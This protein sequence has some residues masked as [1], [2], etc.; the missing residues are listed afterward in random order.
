[1]LFRSGTEALSSLEAGGIEAAI[2]DINMPELSGY[3]VAKL[4]RQMEPPGE[5]LPIIGL[6]AEA[7]SETDRLCREAGMDAAIVKPVPPDEMLALLTRLVEST[8][9]QRRVPIS[10]MVVTP[11]TAHPRFAR[12][13]AII[14][15]DALNALAG[16]GDDAFYHD[17]LE[18]FFADAE[19]ILEAMTEA[20]DGRDFKAFKDQIHAMRSSAVNVGAVR[21]CQ[22]LQDANEISADELGGSAS[23][24]ALAR[25]RGELGAL[26]AELGKFTPQRRPAE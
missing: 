20:R 4:Y 2:L 5:H 9:Q 26:K 17:V 13:A 25:L 3:H 12:E 8:P 14:D 16:L 19:Q 22:S 7:T 24:A 15:S 23:T 1:M 6:T 21:L 18:A 11:I 10:N